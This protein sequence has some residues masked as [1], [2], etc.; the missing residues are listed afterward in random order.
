MLLCIIYYYYTM[1]LL[2]ITIS[3]LVLLMDYIFIITILLFSMV[4]ISIIYWELV[5]IYCLQ[6][7][8]LTFTNLFTKAGL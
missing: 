6:E 2:I 8:V 4:F 7:L 3:P 5:F 1:D